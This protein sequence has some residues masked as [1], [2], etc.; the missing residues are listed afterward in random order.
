MTIPVDQLIVPSTSDQYLAKMLQVAQTIGL[1]VTTWQEGDPSLTILEILSDVQ[2]SR[3]NPIETSIVKGLLLDFAADPSVTPEPV[4][5]V[6]YQ[7]GWLDMTADQLY[8][9]TRQPATYASAQIQFV[10]STGG[11]ILYPA[12]TYHVQDSAIPPTSTYT[13]TVD[14]TLP[15]GASGPFAVQCDTVGG[16]QVAPTTTLTPVPGLAVTVIAAS[17]APGADAEANAALVTRCRAKFQTLSTGGPSGAYDYFARTIPTETPA[18]VQSGLRAVPTNPVTRTSMLP[19]SPG[20]LPIP[21]LVLFVASAAGE[22]ALVDQ[23]TDSANIQ[24]DNAVVGAGIV[25]ITTHI[26]HGY[27]NGDNVY[28]NGIGGI[29]GVNSTATNP[30]WPATVTAP[31]AFTVPATATGAYTSGGTAYRVAD[32]D[33]VKRNLIKYCVP[34]GILIDVFSA[35]ADPLTIEYT[36]EVHAA[37][38]TQAL[39]NKINAAITSYI[40]NVP[41]GGLPLSGGGNGVPFGSVLGT[42]WLQDPV[43]LISVHV[44]LNGVTD[45]DW[46]AAGVDSVIALAPIVPALVTDPDVVIK[47]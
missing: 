22:Y 15:P 44:I 46:T 29:A 36:I 16:G 24:I 30:T 1:T 41:I 38:A 18:V 27:S 45:T 34:E 3:D 32:L 2:A 39:I 8:D 43:N 12:G 7:G 20:V 11:T 4:R 26:N 9:T 5:G 28:L 19:L 47:P 14:L 13:N 37:G 23:Y 40:A 42:I 21:D 10:N 17:F 25:T 33:L 6:V 35:V 31:D